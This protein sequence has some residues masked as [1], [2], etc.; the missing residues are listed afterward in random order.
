MKKKLVLGIA[1]AVVAIPL[2]GIGLVVAIDSLLYSPAPAGSDGNFGSERYVYTPTT[3][4]LVDGETVRWAAGT[5]YWY[6]IE[7]GYTDYGRGDVAYQWTSTNKD[8][9]KLCVVPWK[10]RNADDPRTAWGCD[11]T[12]YD[13]EGAVDG[14]APGMYALW[15]DCTNWMQDCR[16]YAT[17]TA[18]Y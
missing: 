17:L 10:D 11:A 3:R 15:M 18:T 8:N 4:T 1:A 9:A 13:Y 16:G 2:A 6:G 7:I 12:G 5:V 14:L